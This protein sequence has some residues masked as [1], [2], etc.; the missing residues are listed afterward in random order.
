MACGEP[1]SWQQFPFELT[2]RHVYSDE[3]GAGH[4]A[5]RLISCFSIELIAK[6]CPYV[7]WPHCDGE[8]RGAR[9]DA[10]IVDHHIEAAVFD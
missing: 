7:A 8:N 10:G 3:E 1:R 2:C 5:R 4:Q 9:P 6:D